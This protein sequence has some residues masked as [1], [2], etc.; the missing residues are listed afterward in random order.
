LNRTD[1][2]KTVAFLHERFN[3]SHFAGLAEFQG[4]NVAE[5]SALRHELRAAGTEFRVVKN[6]IAK[7]ALKGTLLE[8]LDEHFIGSTAVALSAEDPVAPAKILTRFSKENP[9]LKIKAGLLEGNPLSLEDLNELSKLPGREA[10][11]AKLLGVLQGTPSGLVNVLAGVLRN[12][13]G[14]LHAIEEEKSK[15]SDS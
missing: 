12:F 2:E 10:L 6:S 3:D 8:V 5:I 14:T 7:R 9:K 13:L 11:L 1:K 4:L 15:T